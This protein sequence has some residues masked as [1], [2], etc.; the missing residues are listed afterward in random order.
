MVFQQF[1]GINGVQFYASETFEAAGNYMLHLLVFV[2]LVFHVKPTLL[3]NAG[4]SGSFGTIAYACLQVTTFGL[5]L[6][7][8]FVHRK[9]SS[10][11]IY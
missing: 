6:M 11:E 10:C 2:L 9:L 8:K 1:A 4:V 5:P 3:L 7:F